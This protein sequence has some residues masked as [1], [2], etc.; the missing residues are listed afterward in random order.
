MNVLEELKCFY[1]EWAG[2]KGY[3]GCTENGVPIPFFA[4][5]KTERPVILA[6]YAIHAREYITTYLGM[7]QANDFAKS[8]K[9]GTVYFIPAVNLDGIAEVLFGD[10]LYK[11]NANRVDLNVNFDAR[12]G[13]G[14]KNLRE[15]SSENYIG[16][17]PFSES[18]TRALRDFTLTVRPDMTL[19]YHSKGEEIYWEFYQSGEQRLRDFAIAKAVSAATGY[20]VKSAGVSCGGY[21]DWCVEKLRIPALTVEVGDDGLTHPIGKEFAEDIFIKNREVLRILTEML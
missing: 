2:V 14:A 6:Q 1:R 7:M 13:G 5:K 4:V 10:K 19:S 12:W 21:K 18:E 16:E 9:R 11:A 15:K 8:G 20:P 17:Y 3:I